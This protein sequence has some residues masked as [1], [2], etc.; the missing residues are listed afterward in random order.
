MRSMGDCSSL[1]FG[2]Q[3]VTSHTLIVNGSLSAGSSA[4]SFEDGSTPGANSGGIPSPANSQP[5][6]ATLAPPDV[7][8]ADQHS[9]LS[10][11]GSVV[12]YETLM[13]PPRSTL[14]PKFD[15]SILSTGP[16]MITWSLPGSDFSITSAMY[17]AR[18]P[19]RCNF[20]LEAEKFHS[21]QEKARDN[22]LAKTSENDPSTTIIPVEW[23]IDTSSTGGLPDTK[24]GDKESPIQECISAYA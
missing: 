5:S 24:C 21:P 4:L 1:F 15:D 6:F 22:M 12:P 8:M 2:I 16:N 18:I 19:I 3:P 20:E 23:C 10:G 11:T 14:L 7:A 13:L 17:V 9:T